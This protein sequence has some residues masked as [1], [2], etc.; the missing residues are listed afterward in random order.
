MKK[1]LILLL[2]VS[3]LFSCNKIRTSQLEDEVRDAIADDFRT[4]PDFMGVRV[5]DVSL[6][7]VEGNTYT[8]FVDLTYDGDTYQHTVSVVC[9]GDYFIWE[10]Y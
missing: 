3:T 5:G 8:G 2:L 6:V 9:D 1:I 10:V 4:D 7:N